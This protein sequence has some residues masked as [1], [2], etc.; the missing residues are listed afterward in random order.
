VELPE[1]LVPDVAAW[2]AWLADHHEGSP[3]VRLVLAKKGTTEPTS[4]SYEQALQ[5]ALCFG[6]IDGQVGRRDEATMYQRFTPRRSRSV[7]SKNN[8][9][10]VA[11]L[12]EEGRMQPAGQAAVDGAKADGRWEAA[13]A[14]PATMTVPDDVAAALR[15]EPGAAQTFEKLTS[16]NRFA[17][18]FRVGQAKR[19]E[20]RARRIEQFVAMLARGEAIYPQKGLQQKGSAQEGSVQE[21]SVQPDEAT[22]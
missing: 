4:L 10:R 7:W 9:E 14:G 1:L 19:A 13:Y 3:G 22:P 5:E 6:W 8:V 20:T 2:H 21:D 15:L 18:L 17:I 12:V 11:R 16:Q